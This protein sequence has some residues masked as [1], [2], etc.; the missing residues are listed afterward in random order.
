MENY[1]KEQQCINGWYNVSNPVLNC[2]IKN[3]STKGFCL[4]CME[5][6]R[7][8]NGYYY[9]DFEDPDDD[10][11]L[12]RLAAG[13]KPFG[14]FPRLRR[15]KQLEKDIKRL[16]LYL[17]RKFRNPWGMLCYDV[18]KNPTLNLSD[19]ADLKKIGKLLNIELK[20]ELVID[21]KLDQLPRV[22]HGLVYDYPFYT[23]HPYNYKL[24]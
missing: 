7:Y 6:F 8:R 15:D 17:I 23:L 19:L 2:C 10:E 24:L 14:T 9:D 4:T 18:V 20:D 22:Y 12:E 1:I 11:L 3:K 16:G 21:L 5:N 13:K